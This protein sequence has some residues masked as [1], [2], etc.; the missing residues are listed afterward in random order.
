MGKI[1]IAI[2]GA[3]M[4]TGKFSDLTTDMDDIFALTGGAMTSQFKPVYAFAK[5]IEERFGQVDQIVGHSVG[6]HLATCLLPAFPDAKIMAYDSPGLS[7]ALMHH[8]GKAYG[9]T[10]Q[11]ILALYDEKAPNVLQIANG[12]NSLNT[13]GWMPRELTLIDPDHDP[14]KPGPP[15]NLLP[16]SHFYG[17]GYYT[18]I[19]K[20][21]PAKN[22]GAPHLFNIRHDANDRS[23]GPLVVTGVMLAGTGGMLLAP[24][25]AAIVLSAAVVQ[26][27]VGVTHDNPG[28]LTPNET[29]ID[30]SGAHLLP[31]PKKLTDKPMI[32]R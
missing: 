27:L 1:T 22:D 25:G 18:A 7:K 23:N 21:D 20:L 10:D 14:Y 32:H 24:A 8:L 9:K 11:E 19:Q 12:K 26:G 31:L 5:A 15:K 13:L 16:T 2:A 3:D 30:S 29:D 28:K 6:A 4:T 17:K